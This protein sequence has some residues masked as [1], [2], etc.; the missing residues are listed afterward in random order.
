MHSQSMSINVV[1]A[2]EKAK[3]FRGKEP[4]D[5]PFIDT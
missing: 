1:T 5:V 4:T 2:E 3:I